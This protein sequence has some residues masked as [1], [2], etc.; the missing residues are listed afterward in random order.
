MAAF[1]ATIGGSPVNVIAGTLRV[2]NQI[3]QR[4][5]G[6][7]GVWSA[8]GT[9]WQYGTRVIVTDDQ[10][11]VVYSGYV[12]KDK[13]TRGAGA[14]QGVG[15]LE[16]DISLMD[17]CYRADKRRVFKTYLGVTADYI[18]N[19]LLNYYLVAEGVSSTPTSIAAGPLITEVIW[20]GT[21]SVS[22]ALTWLCTQAGYWWQIDHTGTLFFQPYSGQTATMT[23]D[24]TSV[25]AMQDLSV[26]FGNDMFVNKQY[27]KGGYAEIKAV[28]NSFTANGVQTQWVCSYPLSSKVSINVG[29]TVYTGASLGTKGV[30]NGL[31]WYWAVGDAVI[32]QDPSAS[33]VPNGV[34]ITVTYNGRF[35]CIASAQNQA[36]I[37]AQQA[38]EGGGTG[39]VES[40]Y[41]NLKV[42]T[43]PA[44]Y[45]IAAALLAHYGDTMT[46]LT[47]STRT[48]GFQPGQMANVVLSDF[49]LNQQML[50][51][52]VTID[53]Q[54]PEGFNVWY[55]VTAVGSPVEVAQ[56]QT[57][58]QNLMNQSSD[59]SD[60]QD[61]G[62]SFLA[63]LSTT[64]ATRSP[65]V[66]VTQTLTTCPIC[67][68]ATLC[69][70]S[71]IV[72]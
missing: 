25:D 43:L 33:P 55:R 51:Y 62:D 72:C 21:K 11:S 24:G 8:L 23:I 4:S 60:F 71:T 27:T 54:G 36:Q 42:H 58:Y 57:F 45:Q 17:N 53:D 35:P 7:I 5:T 34:T 70:T 9:T 14:R 15:Y 40:C 50:I 18:V 20:S 56:W 30:D 39:L 29:G 6:Q 37:T 19:D 66:T 31:P 68:N 59:P 16:H 22:D 12:V 67:N 61:V 1:T 64:T 28:S 47:F 26:E 52:A 3:G 48:R 46:T 44:A 65:M 41:V 32:A 49:G 69:N 38:L 13:A 63:L 10:G 2:D